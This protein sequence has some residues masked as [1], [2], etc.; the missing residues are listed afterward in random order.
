M[1]SSAF[2]DEQSQ[3]N[4]TFT[5]IDIIYDNS[6]TLYCLRQEVENF[7][8]NQET[9]EGSFQAQGYYAVQEDQ[10]PV[11]LQFF[12]YEGEKLTHYKV[13]VHKKIKLEDIEEEGF[14]DDDLGQ[15]PTFG[16]DDE[17]P[18]CRIVLFPEYIFQVFFKVLETNPVERKTSKETET[19]TIPL[20][21]TQETNKEESDD[22]V[23]KIL[24]DMNRQSNY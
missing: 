14:E 23:S 16:E 5:P 18:G 2:A 10:L 21:H 20:T 3:S 19:K 8:V 6:P 4:P 15:H 17:Y 24:R 13:E 12:L 1:S 7:T 9:K 22:L 11:N